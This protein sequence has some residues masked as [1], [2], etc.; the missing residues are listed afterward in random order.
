M[1]TVIQ[2]VRAGRGGATHGHY[3][4]QTA[5]I[6]EKALSH[7]A[8]WPR[9]LFGELELDFWKNFLDTGL[10][11]GLA[12][13]QGVSESVKAPD[14]ASRLRIFNPTIHTGFW[15]HITACMVT[16]PESPALSFIPAQ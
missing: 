4:F 12:R 10:R 8:S 15:L 5:A 9:G 1:L 6:A 11:L 16:R 3:A 14:S 2:R 7:L 13:R